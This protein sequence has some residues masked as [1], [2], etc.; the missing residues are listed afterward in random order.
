MTFTVTFEVFPH[1]EGPLSIISKI[2][3]DL[4]LKTSQISLSPRKISLDSPG[5]FLLSLPQLLLL[6]SLNL[7]IHFK[8]RILLAYHHFPCSSLLLPNRTTELS[9]ICVL[10]S[11]FLKHNIDLYVQQLHNQCVD[12]P[13]QHKRNLLRILIYQ[14]LQLSKTQLIN[15]HSVHMTIGIDSQYR[16]AKSIDNSS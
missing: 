1:V 6:P 15:P 14:N 10:L 16:I 12:L 4:L 2:K 8:F 13:L 9:W 5:L 11:I 3:M 7:E